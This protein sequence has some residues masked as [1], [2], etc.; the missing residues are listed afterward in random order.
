MFQKRSGMEKK[1]WIRRWY[2]GFPLVFFVSQSRE[3]SLGN[4]SV[5]QK[6]LVIKFIMHRRGYHTSLNFCLR[7][8]K[9]SLGGT[10]GFRKVPVWKKLMDNREGL[11]FFRRTFFVSRCRKN[12]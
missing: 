3:V 2:H 12:S 1:I 5:F 4:L 7:V 10:F 9:K 6:V 11:K 8:P